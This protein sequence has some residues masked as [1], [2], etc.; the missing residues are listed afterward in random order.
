MNTLSL[1]QNVFREAMASVCT[2]VSVVTTLADDPPHG[3]TDSA[4][5]SLSMDPVSFDRGSDLLA[6]VRRTERFGLNVSSSTQADLAWN[7][8][9]KGGGKLAG[10]D[11][12]VESGV[13]RIHGASSF[14]ACR[15]D[16]PVEAG[17]HVVA[18]GF[19]LAADVSTASPLTCHAHDFGTRAPFA[20][21]P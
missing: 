6:L 5:V 12:E 11:W 9:R 17:D 18:L 10:V 2:P 21:E 20:K 3:T 7:F 15:V 14:V 13:P 16:K 1:L 19:A 4:F 8:A